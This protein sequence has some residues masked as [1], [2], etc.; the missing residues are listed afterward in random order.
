[1]H[2]ELGYRQLMVE[3]QNHC[4]DAENI[5]HHFHF[6]NFEI[7]FY[8]CETPIAFLLLFLM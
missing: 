1:M 3:F 7:V 4:F 5:F 8:K 6:Q 2:P